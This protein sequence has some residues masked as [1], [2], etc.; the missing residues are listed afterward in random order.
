VETQEHVMAVQKIR[1]YLD[2]NDIRYILIVHSPAYTAQEIAANAHIPGD[3][4]AKSVILKIDGTLAMCVLPASRRLDL[5][6]CKAA[7]KG[8]NVR[9]ASENEFR[10]H[11]PECELGAI[12]PF[13]NLFG[14]P[15]FVSKELSRNKELAFNAGTHREVIKLAYDD[16]HRLVNPTVLDLCAKD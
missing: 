13:G 6:K 8:E 15:V 11:F 12:P 5:Q 9:L 2:E 10:E 1:K 16:Y 7:L 14:L 4:L 3:I